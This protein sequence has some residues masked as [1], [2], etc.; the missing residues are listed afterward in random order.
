VSLYGRTKLEAEEALAQAADNLPI[1][2][3]RPP[4]V[5]GP[6]DRNLL[7]LY[8]S[9]QRGWDFYSDA[10]FQ[11]SFLYVDDLVQ[12]MI[13]AVELGRRL[14]EPADPQR[15]GVYYGADPQAV[16]FPQLAEMVGAAIGRQR[17]RHVRIAPPLGWSLA[18]CG[19]LTQR[20]LRRRVFLN[21]DKAREAYGGSWVCDSSRAKMELG[22]APGASL[23]QR[24]EETAQD[25]LSAG[26]LPAI[27]RST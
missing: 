10:A 19:E 21:R 22:F 17:I 20:I 11:Y 1:T 25:Y 4:C 23:A 24:L 3:V 15:R 2:I 7:G 5:F 26:W 6:G 8:R 27:G 12:L 14:I 16:T 9:V 13:A 18:L